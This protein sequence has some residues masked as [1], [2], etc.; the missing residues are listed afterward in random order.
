M[1]IYQVKVFL[2]VARCLSFTE[3]ADALNLTQPAVTA[4]IKSL[5]SEVGSP[6]FYRLGRKIQLTEVGNSLFDQGH[7]LVNL[8]NQIKKTI[9]EVKQGKSG[10]LR[11]G[12]TS[13]VVDSWL[14]DVIFRYRHLHPEIRTYCI[15]F[16]DAE[17]LY[18]AITDKQVDA[19]ISDIS[20]ET[21]SEISSTSIDA[22]RYSLIVS[23]KNYLASQTWLSLKDLRDKPWVLL[24]S[25][26]PSRLIFETR[27]AEFGLHLSDFSQVEIVDSFSLMRAFISQGNYLGFASSLDFRAD[28]ASNLLVSVPLQEFALAGSIFLILPARLSQSAASGS[29][30]SKRSQ[31]SRHLS[32]VQ[33]FIALVKSL[34]GKQTSLSSPVSSQE[35]ATCEPL[36]TTAHSHGLETKTVSPKLSEELPS[37]RF[38]S[39]SFVIRPANSNRSQTITLSI[40]VQNRTIPTVTA[41]LIIRNLGLLEHFLPQQGRYS[42]TQYEV[43]WHDFYSG[44]P[45]LKGLQSQQL[46]IGVVGDY[47]LILSALQHNDSLRSISETQ[48]VSFVASN[49]DGSGSAVIVPHKS[50]LNSVEDLGGRVL[51]LPFDTLAYGM[52]IRSLHSSNLLSAVKLDSLN[53]S[54]FN[55]MFEGKKKSVDAYAHFAPYHEIAIRQGEFRSLFSGNSG[56]LPA[57]YGVVIQKSFGEK[58]PEVVVAYLRALMAAQYWYAATPSSVMLTSRW[59]GLKPEVIS[60]ILACSGSQQLSGQFFPE[61]QIRS[62]W[63]DKHISQLKRI[64]G[65]DYLKE[66]DLS[67]WIQMEF[68]QEAR[69]LTQRFLQ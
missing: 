21:F 16:S 60:Y 69:K 45:I 68:L 10:S 38:D 30:R 11:I 32:S 46:D 58:H 4:K 53:L 23:P 44:E 24:P 40:G 25:G 51:S 67:E 42:S 62:D 37:I 18:R 50:E 48:L 33:K 41:G 29:N 2:E 39:P 64:P 47:P 55:K 26:S 9:E 13:I 3:A 7:C 27:I 65:N 59:T 12:C 57:F 17:S 14:P 6:L 54:S 20:F 52:V 22:V 19:G 5:E 56:G 35:S 34:S 63:L 49:P 61:T 1:E 8:E 66:I 36:T 31:A 15:A 28:L 43:K